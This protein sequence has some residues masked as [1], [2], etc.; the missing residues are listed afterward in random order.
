MAGKAGLF[1]GWAM[2]TTLPV[3]I[4]AGGPF[5]VASLNPARTFGPALFTGDLANPL[6][7]LIYFVGPLAG[8]A[9]CVFRFM[10][11][12]A[13]PLVTAKATARRK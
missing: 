13:R 2:G 1:A 7:Y 4:P 3:A 8:A 10:K 9:S 6:T 11:A 5:T 12:E